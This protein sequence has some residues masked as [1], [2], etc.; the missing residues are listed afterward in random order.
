MSS[1][2]LLHT[3]DL[4]NRLS[5]GQA[6]RLGMLRVSLGR[7]GLLL[8]AGDAISAGNVT[9]RPGGEPILDRMSGAGYD[10]MVI[11]NRE[12]HFTRAGFEAKVQ[13]AR[14]PILCSN[15]RARDSAGLLPV[16]PSL[17]CVLEDGFRVAL[18]GLTVP[19]ITEAMLVRRVSAFVF[20]NPL[21]TAER[22]VAQ[23]RPE[24]DL[25]VCLSHLG[26][27]KDRELAQRVGGI[28]LIIGGHTHALLETGERVGNTLIVQA[29][30]HGRYLGRVQVEFK[31]GK[32]FLTANIEP[33]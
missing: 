18:F 9:F 29:G 28:D 23:L 16:L 26:L 27:G 24:C 10:A 30:S 3:N 2:T 25:L 31:E 20:G 4:H 17:R 1:Y 13:Q 15:L 7:R 22:L 14:F 19:M 12:F 8:D 32:A 21:H 6:D 5:P 11:G 33:L